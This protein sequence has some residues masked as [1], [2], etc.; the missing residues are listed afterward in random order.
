VG[1]KARGRHGK[2]TVG[3]KAAA[4][5]NWSPRPGRGDGLRAAIAGQGN[6]GGRVPPSHRK[7]RKA[8]CRGKPGVPHVGAIMYR[9]LYGRDCQYA[10]RWNR[11]QRDFDG[12]TW[13]CQHREEC[14]HCG[15]ILRARGQLL[16]GEC[17][18]YHAPGELLPGR[19]YAR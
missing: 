9:P 6:C 15:R 5:N 17:P 2:A 14:I 4:R 10:K 18:D 1:R 3:G 16:P 7:N 11:K 12:V 19:Q 13:S 8:N